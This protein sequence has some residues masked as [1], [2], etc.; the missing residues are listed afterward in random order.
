MKEPTMMP[1]YAF[2][3]AAKRLVQQTGCKPTHAH[4][5][6]AK[7]L[8]YSCHNAYLAKLKELKQ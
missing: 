5:A 6:L 8:G 2:K 3:L 1:R 7:A 4:E